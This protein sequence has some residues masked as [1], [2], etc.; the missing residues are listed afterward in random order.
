VV[1]SP[2][3]AVDTNAA[4][5]AGGAAAAAALATL[6]G[7]AV[8]AQTVTAA[9]AANGGGSG[10][11]PAGPSPPPPPSIHVHLLS[12]GDAEETMAK[13]IAAVAAERGRGEEQAAPVPK[14][15]TSGADAQA[16][17]AAAVS[18]LETALV[19]A[20]GPAA[21]AEPGVALVY[22]SAF[23]L[24]G[25]PPWALRSAEIYSMGRLRDAEGRGVRGAL[26]RYG[27]TVQRF[28]A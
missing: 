17:T 23:T 10:P 2:L 22:G 16:A 3:S 15:S 12:A 21:L 14:P 6:S 28:G 13:A 4:R 18:R 24:A 20:S 26:A 7:A 1:A 27:A 8:A 9:K 25:Y 11:P 19:T 5:R